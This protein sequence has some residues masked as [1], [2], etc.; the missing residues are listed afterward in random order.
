MAVEISLLKFEVIVNMRFTLSSSTFIGKKD[1]G[2]WTERVGWN[3]KKL[4]NGDFELGQ[5]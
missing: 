1:K 3:V 4:P 2:R 5:V